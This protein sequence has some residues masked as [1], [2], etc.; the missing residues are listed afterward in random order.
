MY[1]ENYKLH[2]YDSLNFNNIHTNHKIFLN[3]MLPIKTNINLIYETVHHQNNVYDCGV[4][5]IAF[6][7]S[8]I[9]SQC[10]CS[11]TYEKKLMRK[12]LIAM[13]QNNFLQPFPTVKV[14]AGIIIDNI[15]DVRHSNLVISKNFIDEFKNIDI[16][17]LEILKDKFLAREAK[18]LYANYT[19]N[20]DGSTTKAQLKSTKK[21]SENRK[22][23]R[24]LIRKQYKDD[25][26]LQRVKICRKKGENLY[27]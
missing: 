9:F 26:I 10:P 12:H 24:K 14:I 3:C 17:Q 11:V 22:R 2:I 16:N 20:E 19:V 8:F 21:D 23:I 5:S 4:F 27:E 13:F 7:T 15:Y 6:A 25:D 18:K 1:Y